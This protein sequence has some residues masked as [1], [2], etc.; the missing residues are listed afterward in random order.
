MTRV[1]NFSAG[2]AALPEEVLQQAAA[3]M[4]DWR[5]SGMS[6]A[7]MSHRS[8]EFMSIL[9]AAQ[10]DLR[11]L[12]AIPANYRILFMQG[13]ATAQNAMIPMNLL[14]RFPQPATVDFIHTGRWAG[15]SIDEAGKYCH[16]NVA[17]SWQQ[18]D[19]T[20]IP[21]EETW[22]LSKNAAYV[23]ICTNETVHGIEFHFIPDV[24]G[25]PL[26]ADM[27]SHLLSREV[28]VSKYGVIFAGAQKNMGIAGLTVVIVREDLIGNALPF[29]PSVFDWKNVAQHDSMFNTPPTF[30]IYIAGLVFQWLKRQGGVAAIEQRNISKAALLYD[31]LD[32][33]G[34]YRNL[35]ARDCRSRM[36]VPFFLRDESLNAVFLA[37]AKDRGLVQLK[38]H[39]ILGGMRASI[40]NAMPVE[41][42]QVLVDYLREFEKRHG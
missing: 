4:L 2:P 40:Y 3:E 31:Y 8:P 33:T 9:Q 5:C 39:R 28:E 21:P 6:V 1:F 20:G 25:V 26:V 22:K 19:F 13:G 32:S 11:E 35:V 12:L 10:Q 24:G 36:N 15:R 23:H 14:G 18:T 41:G 37:G 29:C 27:S 34:F 42:V 16:V 17:A 38:G 7:E 30:A